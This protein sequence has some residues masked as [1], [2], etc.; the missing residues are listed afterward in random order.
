MKIRHKILLSLLSIL[1]LL[2]L[3]AL[4]TYRASLEVSFYQKRLEFFG[5]QLSGLTNLRAQ[6]RNQILE[7]YEVCFVE[8]IK[9]HESDIQ[10]QRARVKIRFAELEQVFPTKDMETE[11]NLHQLE[12]E[13]SLLDAGLQEGISAVKRGL[14]S[15]GKK[16]IL[17]VREKRFNQG[18]IKNIST[19]I[20]A[21]KELTKRSSQEL[22]QSISKLKKTIGLFAV[23]ALFLVI[24]ITVFLSKS[25]G[26]RLAAMESATRQISDGD[27]K[28]SIPEKGSDEV[29]ILA[30][31]FNEMALSLDETRE[32]LRQQQEVVAH[33]SKM[34]ALGEMAGGIA[35]E[36]NTPLAIIQMRAGQLLEQI[37]LNTVDLKKMKASLQ[38][39]DLTVQRIGK[40]IKGLRSFARDGRHDP[41]TL[42][43]I[44]K[45]VEDTFSLCQERFRNHGISLEFL[46]EGDAEI[47]CRPSEIGQVLLNLLNN[48]FDAIQENSQRWV[49]VE[50]RDGQQEIFLLISDSGR[51][52]PNELQQKIMQPFFTTKEVGKG[53]GLGLSI[54]KGIIEGHFGELLIDNSGPNTTFVIKFRKNQS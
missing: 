47:L 35:H 6:V 39:I 13:Y 36:I 38:G 52:I 16:I 22:D 27:F 17:D 25:I 46:H 41:L 23:I 53:T 50:L 12:L 21:Q 19:L 30:K 26:G 4:T 14:I 18:F 45:I 40:I 15:D 1:G 20:D 37:E 51:G 34:S 49:K 2:I 10:E 44:V 32:R 9:D 29:S 54:S 24:G 7:T 3:I 28:I 33:S 48:S 31:S 42:N 5:T 8:G 11:S 43:S